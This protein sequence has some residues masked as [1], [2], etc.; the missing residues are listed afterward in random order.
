MNE[1]ALFAGT[2]GDPVHIQEQEIM[3]TYNINRHLAL[4]SR[5]FPH[6]KR[7]LP[8]RSVLVAC[9]E[10]QAVTKALRAVG[11]E[12]YSADFLPCSGGRPEWHIQGDVRPLL[13]LRWRGVIAFPTCTY[14]WQHL[15]K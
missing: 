7:S 13:K 10:S 5:W 11:V 3:S 8:A 6:S 1:L 2:G 9:E 4:I 15:L 14:Q 12:A